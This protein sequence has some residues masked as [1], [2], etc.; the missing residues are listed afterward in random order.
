MVGSDGIGELLARMNEAGGFAISL[1][2]DKDG[3]LIAASGGPDQDPRKESAVVA[4][5]QK[6]ASQ[7]SDR[8]NLS[9]ADEI[10]LFDKQGQRLVCRPFSANGYPLI[11]AVLVPDKYKAYRRLTNKMITTLRRK[12]KL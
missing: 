9:A 7:A 11:L 2:A 6:A 3:F 8:L 4:M 10:S 1:L 5:V 12:W